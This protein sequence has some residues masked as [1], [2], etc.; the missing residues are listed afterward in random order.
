MIRGWHTAKIPD[1]A[2]GDEVE[3]LPA[4]EP[5]TAV[6]VAGVVDDWTEAAV[7]RPA[8]GTHP[9]RVRVV[10]RQRLD[11]QPSPNPPPAPAA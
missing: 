2:A 10:A 4:V 7:E 6:G 8:V 1:R 3:G 5:D 9:R 11:Q